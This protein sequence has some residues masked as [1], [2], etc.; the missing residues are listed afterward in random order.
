[1]EAKKPSVKLNTAG[2]PAQ[3]VRLYGY[4]S[5]LSLSILSNFREFAV[6]DTRIGPK[7]G[8]GPKVARVAYYTYDRFADHW[9]EIESR[10]SKRA[11]LQGSFDRFVVS[12][13]AKKGTEE[14]DERFLA[15]MRTWRFSLATNIALRNQ[16]LG[17]RDLS[18]TVQR[19]LDRIV[20]LR[21]CEDRG[22]EPYGQLRDL[23]KD[24]EI[25]V[26]LAELFVRADARYNSGLF[27][28]K[29]ER[30]REEN[31]DPAALSLIVDD[32]K[33]KTILRELYYPERPYTFERMPLDILGKVY[34]QF[35]AQVVR[36]TPKRQ[37]RIDDKPELK[38][39]EGVYYTPPFIVQYVVDNTIGPLLENKK[40]KD[41]RGLCILDPACGSGSFLIGAYQ[42]LLR[43][44]LNSYVSSESAADKRK[45]IRS[46]TGDYRLTVDEKKQILLRHI[47]GVDID[48]AAIEVSKL[49]LFLALLEGESQLNLFHEKAL[50]DLGSNLRCGNALIDSQFYDDE[51]MFLIGDEDKYRINAFDWEKKFPKQMPSGFD[52]VIGNP[53]YGY[54]IA[55]PE[56]RFFSS[57][58]RYQDYQMD[59]YL[60]FLERYAY[61]LR[62][63]GR[64]GIITS[65]TWLQSITLRRIRQH[66]VDDYMWDRFLALPDR[67]FEAI[68]DTHVIVLQ[69]DSKKRLRGGNLLVD[70][71]RAGQVERLHELP[72]STIESSGAPINVVHSTGHQSLVK[73]I[74][75]L[76]VPLGRGLR[77]FN[78]IKPFEKGKGVPPQSREVV[79]QKPFVHEG[80][81]PGSDWSPLLR[82]SL[83]RRY[84]VLWDGNYWIKYGPWLAAPRD[85]EIFSADWKV[86]IRQTGDSLICAVVPSGF[87]AR[88]NLHILVP[89]SSVLDVHFIAALLNSKLMDFVYS[90][91]NP[92]KGEALAEVKKHHVENL[93]L[94]DV[95]DDDERILHIGRSARILSGKISKIASA[96]VGHG[97]SVMEREIE[98]LSAQIQRSIFSLYNL[99]QTE[100]EMIEAFAS[101]NLSGSATLLQ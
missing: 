92:E 69:M 49:S 74:S 7:A 14:I 89:R 70:V 51:Q 91:V 73:K 68:V 35:I 42:Y 13:K 87:F 31:E 56:A 67:V 97:R 82:G 61:L 47:F 25:Y 101:K 20:F 36:L 50:P 95:A 85:P 60:L 54:S 2:A 64:L 63:G 48:P 43:W 53:P 55:E 76:S 94:R 38:R 40:P 66:L 78:G 11:V 98:A 33:L 8:D 19:L 12:T 9:E 79:Q 77:C 44:Y 18:A 27:H 24:K 99:T 93:P 39:K 86:M 100:I 17:Q 46:P 84:Q 23:T 83:I 10:F 75:A 28:F 52:A 26:K 90:Y 15:D 22:L 34:E 30:G 45:I 96:T 1:L 72:Q 21:I 29:K 16:Q 62:E 59:L 4:S 6:Y 5:K 58:F 37:V 81:R 41:I 80:T 65:N 3:Q 32:S 71:R 57:H 88:N